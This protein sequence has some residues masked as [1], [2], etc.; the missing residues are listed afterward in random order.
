MEHNEIIRSEENLTNKREQKIPVILLDRSSVPAANLLNQNDWENNNSKRI[1]DSCQTYL[2]FVYYTYTKL[3]K[4][5]NKTALQSLCAHHKSTLLDQWNHTPF[6]IEKISC[7]AEVPEIHLSMLGFFSGIKSFLDLLVELL[8]TEQII[9]SN[10]HGFHEKGD[11]I[12][13]Q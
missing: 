7:L 9:A 12:I 6:K 3:E 10:V 2:G 8:S 5:L 4:A 1:V 11:K 13:R